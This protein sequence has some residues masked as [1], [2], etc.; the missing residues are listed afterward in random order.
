MSYDSVS[1]IIAVFEINTTLKLFF[2]FK[3]HL[4]PTIVGKIHRLLPIN[5]TYHIQKNMLYFELILNCGLEKPKKRFQKG[6]IAYLSQNN[7]ICIFTNNAI[8]NTSLTLIG[9][10]NNIDQI[11]NITSFNTFS[12]YQSNTGLKI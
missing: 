1:R 11:Q 3:R 6:D 4:A 10:T 8:L 9:K 2:E 7:K 5:G 12:L